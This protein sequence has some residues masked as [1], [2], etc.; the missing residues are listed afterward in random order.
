VR[1]RRNDSRRG[2]GGVSAVSVGSRLWLRVVQ[3]PVGSFA[4]FGAIAATVV[5]IINALFLQAGARP[6]PFIATPAPQAAASGGGAAPATQSTLKP[7][8]M[9]PV[10]SVVAPAPVQAASVPLPVPS[11]ARHND[12]IA[13]LIGP[14]P[15]IA[16]VQ[17]VL[18]QFGY[19]QIKQTGVL[20]DATGEAIARFEREHKLPVT[21]RVSDRLVGDLTAMTGRPLE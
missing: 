6:A 14:S 13:D 21:G 9:I 16:A 15:R 20:D 11:P 17:R 3:R 5:I 12:P 2:R 18:S 4:I 19:G 1:D 8:D 10:H 7:A